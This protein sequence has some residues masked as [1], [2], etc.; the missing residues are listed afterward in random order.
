MD[1][2]RRGPS[3]ADPGTRWTEEQARRLLAEWT[4]SGGPLAAFARR[5]GVHPQ[6]LTWWRKRLAHTARVEDAPMV[7]PAFL[8]VTVRVASAAAELAPIVAAIQFG[9]AMRVELRTLDSASACWVAALS[10]ALG[11]AS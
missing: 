2:R 10:R 1:N 3:V 8:P 11:G 5:R 6:R 4:T 7:A 9:D